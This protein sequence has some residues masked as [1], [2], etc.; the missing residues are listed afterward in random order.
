MLLL[1]R[2]PCALQ[3]WSSGSAPTTHCPTHSTQS[4]SAAVPHPH[5]HPGPLRTAPTSQSGTASF[6]LSF[7]PKLH[8]KQGLKVFNTSAL[9]SFKARVQSPTASHWCVPKAGL[10][11]N[12]A[13]PLERLHRGTGEEGGRKERFWGREWGSPSQCPQWSC[14]NLTEVTQVTKTPK[15]GQ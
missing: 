2:V 10:Q 14:T 13:W 8:D 1:L 15:A 5:S 9:G 6:S 7:S 11:P 4:L 3:T 12:L